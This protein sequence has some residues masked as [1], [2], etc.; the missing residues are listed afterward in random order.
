MEKIHFK[1]LNSEYYEY[2][3]TSQSLNCSS[4]YHQNLMLVSYELILTNAKK[5]TVENSMYC[6]S[7]YMVWK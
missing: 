3:Y 6:Y 5:Y 2:I 4:K 7:C 1:L